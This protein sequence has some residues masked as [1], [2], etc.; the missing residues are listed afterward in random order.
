MSGITTRGLLAGLAVI[1]VLTG[2]PAAGQALAVN[3]NPGVLP[4]VAAPY[5]ATY[6]EWG[7][8]WWQWVLSVPA[9]ENP[10]FDTTGEHC[11]RNQAGA[12]WYL[13]GTAGGGAP[14]TRSCTVPAGHALFFPV[15]NFVFIATEPGETEEQAHQ[16]VTEQADGLE[17]SALQVAVDGHSLDQLGSYRA[18]S[19][20]FSV[21]LPEDN[22]FG[23]PAGTYGPAATDGYWVMLHPLRPGEHTVHLTADFGGGSVL[24][25]TYD[26]VVV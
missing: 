10:L 19:P 12:V 17:V 26:L 22:V 23:L 21:A 4:Q 14:V 15:A 3:P 25:V 16:A 8:R 2:G 1:A 11:A 5:G 7:A 18:H 24:D 13:A 6:G 20:T 9:E